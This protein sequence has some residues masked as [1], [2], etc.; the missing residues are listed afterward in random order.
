MSED[1]YSELEA[2]ER[3]EAHQQKQN[4][5]DLYKSDKLNKFLWNEARPHDQHRFCQ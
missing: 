2:F 3:Y 5:I 4:E 1:I